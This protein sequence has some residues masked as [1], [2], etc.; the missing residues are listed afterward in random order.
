MVAPGWKNPDHYLP[1]TKAVFGRGYPSECSALR[2][3]KARAAPCMLAT[4]EHFGLTFFLVD[5]SKTTV[6]TLQ[7]DPMAQRYSM[8]RAILLFALGG[9]FCVLINPFIPSETD[10]HESSGGPTGT[11]LLDASNRTLG[12]RGAYRCFL[13]FLANVQSSSRR[14][15]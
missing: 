7:P 4:F 11:N 12:V 3:Y 2:R 10:K 8:L 6:W 1:R 13:Y 5:D 15:S 9:L 14:Y